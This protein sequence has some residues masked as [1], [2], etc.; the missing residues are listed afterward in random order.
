MATSSAPP[1]SQGAG[2]QRDPRELAEVTESMEAQRKEQ[3]SGRKGRR[4]DPRN[5][6]DTPTPGFDSC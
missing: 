3:L 1:P 5:R 4:Q 2:L 6:M